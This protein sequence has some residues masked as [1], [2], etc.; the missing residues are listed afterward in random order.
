VDSGSWIIGSQHPPILFKP[1][2]PYYS[3]SSSLISYCFVDHY[4]QQKNSR[5][6]RLIWWV[7]VTFV[8]KGE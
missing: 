7:C 5:Q 1:I 8:D 6:L 3:P 2:L 4:S